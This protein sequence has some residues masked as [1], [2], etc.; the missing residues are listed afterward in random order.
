[1]FVIRKVRNQDLY[2]VT[3]SESG[4]IVGVFPTKKEAERIGAGI[5]GLNFK[6]I[7]K[8]S[9]D[10][11]HHNVDGYTVDKELSGRRVKTYVG[12]N[13][14]VVMV[15]RGTQGLQDIIT[16]MKLFVTPKKKLTKIKRFEYAKDMLEKIE[17]KY[18]KENVNVVGHSLGAKIAETIGDEGNK[19]IITY[20]K[21]VLPFRGSTK[22]KNQVDIK[23]TYDPV[24]LLDRKGKKDIV[25]KSKTIDPLREH[26]LAALNDY[27]DDDIQIG[28]KYLRKKSIR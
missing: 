17:N 12:D 9:Y 16:D 25:L 22:K 10:K 26:S 15:N 7:L 18:G 5:T 14:E 11:K 8:S 21:P 19:N 28:G 27:L 1:M 3:N 24:S 2:R 6:K 13:G 20:N 4:E 23:T